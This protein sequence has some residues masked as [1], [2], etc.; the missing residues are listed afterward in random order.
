MPGPYTINRLGDCHSKMFESVCTT[1]RNIPRC[2]ASSQSYEFWR[3]TAIHFSDN[4]VFRELSE[5][6]PE[7][8][9]WARWCCPQ[10][11]VS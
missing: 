8:I 4:A 7:T 9:P 11:L 10:I 6:A 3:H 5:T 1:T 2:T